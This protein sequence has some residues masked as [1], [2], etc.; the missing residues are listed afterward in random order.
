MPFFDLTTISSAE[1]RQ[2][3]TERDTVVACLCAAWCD[4]CWAYRLPFEALT[5]QFPD[6]LFLWIDIED[7]A[8]L[9]GDLEIDNFP[10][11]F[12]RRHS[13]VTFYG[14]MVPDI[15]ALKLVISSQLKQ[16]P[17]QLQPSKNKQASLQHFL[18]LP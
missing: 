9:V 1:L 16:S 11:L 18:H 15:G 4:V 5:S 17:E 3:L 6:I 13:I 7:Q 8:D 14:E 10:T 2:H 12:I